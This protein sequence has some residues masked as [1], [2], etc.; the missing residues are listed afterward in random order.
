M[1]FGPLD[2]GV[3]TAGLVSGIDSAVFADVF[4]GDNLI[5]LAVRRG[6]EDG[7]SRS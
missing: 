7:A 1:T 5:S 2:A 3:A 4:R 6:V